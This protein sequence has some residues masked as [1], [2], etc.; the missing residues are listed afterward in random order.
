MLGWGWKKTIHPEDLDGVLNNWQAA[1]AAGEPLEKKRAFGR[2]TANI[3]GSWI[4][5]RRCATKRETSLSGMRRA[6]TSRTESKRRRSY[7][8]TRESSGASLML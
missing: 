5:P 7:A 6:S 8:K 2:P 1:L 3:G 4:A